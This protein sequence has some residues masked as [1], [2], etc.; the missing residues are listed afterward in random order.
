[1][2]AVEGA[3][4]MNADLEKIN[5]VQNKALEAIKVAE[6]GIEKAKRN[7]EV[8]EKKVIIIYEW[9]TMIKFV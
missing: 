3:K 9:N 7:I 4:K 6:I 1:M 8:A 5:I 2:A